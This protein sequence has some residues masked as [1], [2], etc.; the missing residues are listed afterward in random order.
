MTH[1]VRPDRRARLASLGFGFASLITSSLG[2]ATTSNVPPPRTQ[3]ETIDVAAPAGPFSGGVVVGDMLFA[4]G[5]IGTLP[6]SKQLVQGGIE[7]ETQQAME[8]LAAVLGRAGFSMADIVRCEVYLK[9][10]NDYAAMNGVY[11][12][13][14]AD[15]R[16]PS[17]ATVQVADLVLGARVEVSCIAV[18]GARPRP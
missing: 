1:G 13:F 18:K 8:N 11:S 9:D 4:S 10:M 3:R 6:G 17:R 2:C 16:Y 14:F 12:E 15:E 7:A 5:Q